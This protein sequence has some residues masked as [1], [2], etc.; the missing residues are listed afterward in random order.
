MGF[1]LLVSQLLFCHHY[2]PDVPKDFFLHLLSILCDVAQADASDF[3]QVF[4]RELKCVSGTAVKVSKKSELLRRLI[5]DEV[6]K[7]GK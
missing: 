2:L 6:M 4:G 7:K 1:H 5:Q 3:P